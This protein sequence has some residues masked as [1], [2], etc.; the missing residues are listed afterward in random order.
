MHWFLLMVIHDLS[1]EETSPGEKKE[2]PPAVTPVK[3]DIA[4]PRDVNG[5]LAMRITQ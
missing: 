3:D 5:R 1:G 4:S 2:I